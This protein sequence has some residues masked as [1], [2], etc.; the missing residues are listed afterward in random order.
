LPTD[1]RDQVLADLAKLYYRTPGS[2][3]AALRKT[4]EELNGL[5]LERNRQL[6]A[7]R[8][9]V[10]LL[11]QVVLREDRVYLALSGPLYAYHVHS[12]GVNDYHDPE[13]SGRGL[14]LSRTAPVSFSQS[15]LHS[16]DTILL[17]APPSPDWS[18]LALASIHGQG[19]E[20][21]RRRLFQQSAADLNAVALQAKQGKGKFYLL[22]GAATQ[23][24]QPKIEPAAEKV[25]PVIASASSEPTSQT[26]AVALEKAELAEP[27]ASTAPI[28]GVTAPPIIVQK[29]GS[30]AIAEAEGA[31][32]PADEVI[33]PVRHRRQS[34]FTP[35][36]GFFAAL[37]APLAKGGRRLLEGVRGLLGRMLPDEAF[38]TIPSGVMAL[39]AVAVP[40]TIVTAASMA[41]L[42]LGRTA[43]YELLSTQARQV[44]LQA[45]EQSNLG[46]KRAD[47]G[48]ALA[49]LQKAE[50]YATT[51]ESE[52]E[53]QALRT[54]LRNALDELDFVRRLGYQPAIIGNL[55]V[56]TDIISM[57]AF[58]DELYLLD[59]TSGSVLRASLTD[60][61]YE[62]DYTFQCSPGTYGEIGVGA[63]SEIVAWPPGY[64]P[65]ARLL[66]A[67]SAGN[68]LYCQ[69]NQSPQP[70]RLKPAEA[71]A[72]GDILVST[73]DQGDFYALDLPSNG[74]W[75]YP[76]SDFNEQPTLFFDEQIPAMQNVTDMLVDRDDLYL[77]QSDGN[78]MICVRDT[79][80]VAPTRCSIQSYI[81]R[82]PGR[83]NL[84][85][86]PPVPFLQV[87][88]TPPPDPSLY[89]LEP[90]GQAIYHFSLRNLAFQKQFLPENPLPS[91][92]ATAFAIN[93]DRRYVV[94]ALGNRVFYAAMP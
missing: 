55:P 88:S 86:I 54:E 75:I 39:I 14:G 4:A 67:D 44:A 81:D 50:S 24:A 11:A 48:A 34:M 35:L 41:Y 63:I 40:V 7:N 33:Q 2:V 83:E 6:G 25:E 64:E 27:A 90:R 31:I 73:L 49:L 43:Q 78:M 79:L 1:K 68:V 19:P 65:E 36:E 60:Q 46:E 92:D 37:G 42:R 51:P 53:I 74:V 70:E 82:R 8:Q 52:A 10:G 5:L 12:N 30:G 38:L 15:A 45:M 84:P 26:G 93:H 3:T 80:V 61:G 22:W 72:W 20:S 69:Q 85:L 23:A 59:A 89:L 76:R 94:L 77:L 91:H 32:A 57:V 21:L 18:P 71:E 17:A 56:T 87:L 9:S 28:S 29:T 58:D 13:L 16:N 66:A 62:M 47:L